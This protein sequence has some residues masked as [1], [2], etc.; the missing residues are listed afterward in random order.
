MSEFDDKYFY[1]NADA[2][3]CELPLSGTLPGIYKSRDRLK[4]FIKQIFIFGVQ[5]GERRMK[6][7][8][9]VIREASDDRRP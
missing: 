1:D 6:E 9:T 7:N 5:E 8:G 4:V 2:L 3:L